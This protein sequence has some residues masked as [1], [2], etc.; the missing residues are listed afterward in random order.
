MANLPTKSLH[1]TQQSIEM[2]FLVMILM[3]IGLEYSGLISAIQKNW[4]DEIT[5]LA[6]AILQIIRH[7]KSMEGTE[8]HKSVL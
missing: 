5:N 1:Y 7:F 6:E 2:Y 4:K 3:N 8:K